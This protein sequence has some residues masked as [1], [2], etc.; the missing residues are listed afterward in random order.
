MFCPRS[1]LVFNP[2]WN[3]L[4]SFV[5]LDSAVSIPAI[6][7]FLADTATAAADAPAVDSI[8]RREIRGFTFAALLE[9]VALRED[10]FFMIRSKNI[11][12]LETG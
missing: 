1:V 2:K 3:G 12:G 9:L 8:F 5:A 6:A 7:I 4:G 10:F 11:R